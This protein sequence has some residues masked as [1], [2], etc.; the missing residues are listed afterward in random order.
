MKEYQKLIQEELNGQANF[1]QTFL[2]PFMVIVKSPDRAIDLQLQSDFRN[3]R[4]RLSAPFRRDLDDLRRFF[5]WGGLPGD[6][7]Q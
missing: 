1:Y 3:S 7:F 5:R 6:P 2:E 4:E